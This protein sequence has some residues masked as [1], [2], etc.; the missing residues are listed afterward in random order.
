M[1]AGMLMK[2]ATDGAAMADALSP[3]GGEAGMGRLRRE[4]RVGKLL[5]GDDEQGSSVVVC[6]WRIA[7]VMR[8]WATRAQ[9]VRARKRGALTG[10]EMEAA[11]G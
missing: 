11:A 6:E 8:A 4:G 1:K 10:A 9:Q 3:Q 7:A 5:R 2:T